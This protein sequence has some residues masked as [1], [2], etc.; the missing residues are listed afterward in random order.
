MA[1]LLASGNDLQEIPTDHTDITWFID[2]S[3][4]KDEQGHYQAGYAVMS[5]T[6]ITESS[7]LPEIKSAQ[8][9]KLIALT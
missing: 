2:G 5:T 9:A 3:Y 8:Q 1:Y 4:L 6:D 7:Y